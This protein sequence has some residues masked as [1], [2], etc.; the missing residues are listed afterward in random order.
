LAESDQQGE[1]YPARTIR[2]LVDHFMLTS[3]CQG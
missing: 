2:H 3:Y 1:V